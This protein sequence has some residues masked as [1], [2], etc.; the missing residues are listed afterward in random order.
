[1]NMNLKRWEIA[2]PI[3]EEVDKK[4]Q[5]FDPILRQILFN[6]GITS[7]IQAIKFINAATPGA[8][9]PFN[10][11]S[12]AEAVDRINHAIDKGEYDSKF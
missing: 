12:M 11:L 8:I 7:P 4:L 5:E 1:M 10:L 9:D 6:R 2:Q 3:T